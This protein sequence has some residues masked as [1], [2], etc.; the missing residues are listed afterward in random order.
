MPISSKILIRAPLNIRHHAGTK[1]P[2]TLTESGAISGVHEC[3]LNVY[4]GTP[5][6]APPVGDS[7]WRPSRTCCILDW[8]A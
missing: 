3:G 1:P 7:R 4:K 8:H 2:E 5:F 6:V